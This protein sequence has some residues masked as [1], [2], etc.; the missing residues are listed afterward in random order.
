MLL[1]SVTRLDN[2]PD[3]TLRL[4]FF[5]LHEGRP[6][7]LVAPQE[8]AGEESHRH[9][10]G[11]NAT[12]LSDTRPAVAVVVLATATSFQCSDTKT[13]KLFPKTIFVYT[14]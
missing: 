10:N 6:D 13:G 11:L 5:Q 4:Q 1:F 14:F 9:G 8:A 3:F 12:T 2:L 7:R